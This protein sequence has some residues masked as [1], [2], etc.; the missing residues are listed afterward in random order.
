MTDH[1][2]VV[3]FGRN[4]HKACEELANQGV[5]FVLIENDDETLV[6]IEQNFAYKTINGDGTSDEVLYEA[7]IQKAKAIIT[8][9]PND[10][11]N[12]FLTL[13]A[14]ELRPDIKIIARAS[15]Q[16]SEKKLMRAGATHVIMPDAVGGLH[17][18]RHITKPVVIE[19]L[20][21]LSGGGDVVL[22]EI[23]VNDLKTPYQGKSI[24]EM[25]IR[26][27]TGVSIIGFKDENDK[28]QFHP[29]SK[30]VLNKESVLI[31]AGNPD[32]VRAFKE[33]LC[34]L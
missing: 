4:G 3:G 8:T 32:Q 10:A 25:D 20:D 7:G 23:H 30:V 34:S 1:V 18:A 12:V 33:S 13:T 31:I 28:F 15:E 27:Q 6:H 26:R 2:I 24:E 14:R 19:Y 5:D 9:I 17:M 16:G 22:E 11:E 29:N 21:I